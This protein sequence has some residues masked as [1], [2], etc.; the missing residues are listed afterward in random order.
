MDLSKLHK[1]GERVTV[2]WPGGP[3]D[4]VMEFDHAEA[5]NAPGWEDWFNIHGVVVEPSEPKHHV[6][7]AFYV[8]QVGKGEYALVPFRG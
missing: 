8:H 1:S 6:Y 5:I 3:Y 2:R 7:R 4:F